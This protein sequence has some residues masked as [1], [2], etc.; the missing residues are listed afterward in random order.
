MEINAS[1]KIGLTI[2]INFR[3]ILVVSKIEELR[4]FRLKLYNKI[5]ARWNNC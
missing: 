3:Q 1:E 4:E 2:G 5:I